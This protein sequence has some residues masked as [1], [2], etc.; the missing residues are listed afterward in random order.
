MPDYTGNEFPFLTDL[1]TFIVFLPAY[2]L[3]FT[4]IIPF[5]LFRLLKKSSISTYLNGI[6]ILSAFLYAIN[7]YLTFVSIP[8]RLFVHLLTTFPV[9]IFWAVVINVVT[10]KNQNLLIKAK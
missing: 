8:I 5:L 10:I 4:G 3:Y 2:Y 7:S 1:L 6:F 9:L